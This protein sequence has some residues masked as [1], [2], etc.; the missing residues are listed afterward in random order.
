[1]IDFLVNALDA[2][3]KL[4]E[5]EKDKTAKR[6]ICE[7]AFGACQYHVLMFPSDQRRVEYLWGIYKP[8]FEN[9]LN[10]G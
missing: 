10:E 4:C 9:T 1:M 2:N 3:I 8:Q 5:N 7:R 6:I